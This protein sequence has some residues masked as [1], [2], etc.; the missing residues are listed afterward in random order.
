MTSQTFD[1]LTAKETN[2]TGDTYCS[3]VPPEVDGRWTLAPVC[4]TVLTAASNYTLPLHEATSAKSSHQRRRV[5]DEMGNWTMRSSSRASSS[6]PRP[7]SIPLVRN[8]SMSVPS[9]DRWRL[10]ANLSVERAIS[11]WNLHTHMAFVKVV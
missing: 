1:V 9:R 7:D 3:N 6:K 2:K 11:V 4:V 8:P 10:I 5:R